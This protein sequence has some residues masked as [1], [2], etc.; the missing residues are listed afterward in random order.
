M[1]MMYL[2]R[3]SISKHYAKSTLC[4]SRYPDHR[5]AG[6]SCQLFIRRSDPH[7]AIYSCYCHFTQC[8]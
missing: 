6:G 8:N 2:T 7:S 1:D 3:Q 5:M 4:R